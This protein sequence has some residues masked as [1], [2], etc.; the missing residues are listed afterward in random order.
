MSEP[1]TSAGERARSLIH[2]GRFAEAADA[3]RSGLAVDPDDPQLVL[4]LAI[5][6]CDGGDTAAA[7]SAAEHAVALRPDY[8][9]AHRTLGWAIYK[10]GRYAEAAD[11]LA[12]AV[13]L[14]PHDAET[15]VMRAEAR[16]K[17]A[18]RVNKR[19]RDAL[20]ADA[21][22]HA[23]EAVRLEPA[24]AGG[25]LA[26]AKACITRDN[27][28]GASVWADK[29][30]SV[31]PDN[32]VGHQVLGIVAQLRG[33]T[34]T[35]ADHYVNAGKLDPRSD[36]SIKLLRNLRSALP[37]SGVAVFVVAQVALRSGRAAGGIVALV[38][39]T[40]A[41]AAFVAYRFVW[42]RWAARRAM[43]EE[44]RRALARDRELRGRRRR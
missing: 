31:E 34:R 5:A 39:V 33:D 21:E 35:A 37:I 27:A 7:V 9:L 36:S 28:A 41:L 23:V 6:L 3:A 8:A 10:T 44:A 24:R 42:P 4:L 15:H 14:D 25:Y 32:P 43:S 40:V 22:F 26:H 2:L 13:S 19:L 17:Q 11:R 16:L 18:S 29:A 12:H 30:L 38:V 1:Q 20:I